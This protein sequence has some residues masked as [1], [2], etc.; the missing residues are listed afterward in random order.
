[1][2][3]RAPLDMESA[4]TF[5]AFQSRAQERGYDEAFD[6]QGRPRP[7]WSPL[8]SELTC[9]PASEIRARGD[10]LAKRVREAGVDFDIFSHPTRPTQR[11][12]I[13]LAPVVISA[14]EWRWLEKALCQRARLMN[15]ILQDIYGAQTLMRSGAIPAELV[16]ADPTFLRPCQSILPN[17][18]PL[19][20]F[21]ADIARDENGQW[22]VIDNHSETLAGMGYAIANRVAHSHVTGDIFR[23]CN[24]VRLAQFFQNLQGSLTATAGRDNA[25]IAL[26]TPGPTDQDYF[27]HAYLARYLG[28]I[29]VEGPDLRTKGNQVYLKTLEGLKEVDLLV[30]CV[31]GRQIDALELDP[32]GLSGP[33]GLL[34]VNR[35]MPHLIMN[36]VGSGLVQNRGLGPYLSR[37]SR[38]LLGEDL[39]L[40]D[41]RRH[42]LG[43]PQARREVLDNL[44]TYIVR[45]AQE[46]TGRPGQAELGQEPGALSSAERD[47]LVRSITMRGAALVA[48][49]EFGFSRA[50]TIEGEALSSRPFAIRFFVANMGSDYEVMPGG[51]AMSVDPGRAVSLST[52]DGHNR[53]VWVLSDAEQRPHVSLWRPRMENARVER[54]QRVIQSRVADD[55]FWLG[56]YHERAD[57]LMRVLRGAYRR[58]EEDSGDLDGLT[59]VEKCLRTLLEKS[60]PLQP[61]T[62]DRQIERLCVELTSGADRYRTLKHTCEDLYRCAN[63]GRDRL[64]FEAWQTLSKFRPGDAY[65]NELTRASASAV[66]DLLDEGLS[67][68][69][70]FSGL[71]HE[72]MTRNFGWRFLDVGRRV[73]RAY[74][75]CEL[76]DTLF[77]HVEEPEEET[78]ALRLMLELADSYI[79][80]RSRYRIDPKL[81][82][83]LDLLLLDETN[84]RSLAYQLNATSQHL[85]ALPEGVRGTPLPD[86]KRLLLAALTAVRL[87]DVEVLGAAK[88]RDQLARLMSEQLELLPELSNAIGRHYFNPADDTPHRVH[89]RSETVP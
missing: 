34:R 1:M 14:G 41:A 15:L 36:A 75:L 31:D 85:D 18:G 71:M 73:E 51:L 78:N 7:H 39:L 76:I 37:L 6:S 32:G 16:F 33:A 49:E 46:G 70:A 89:T 67:S 87:A 80:Y 20:F 84:P 52:I 82:L 28:Y 83:T 40:P 23:R 58:I 69:S 26:L 13:D 12:Q 60:G 64:S 53:D 35:A 21:A 19:R 74:N 88:T 68:L 48:E 4:D 38:D 61:R 29:L 54:S 25:R 42:W 8:L 47:A 44:D 63:L 72:N 81:P 56:R 22:R 50:P 10:R 27:S 77:S 43:D 55:L 66:L 30:R 3:H 65:L 5:F 57:W 24:A 2:K 62:T 59:A 17:A 9:L 45:K 86:D 79:T 11:W